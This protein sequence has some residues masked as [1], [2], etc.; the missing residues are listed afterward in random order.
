MILRVICAVALVICGPLRAD[1]VTVFAAASLRNVLTEIVSGYDAGDDVIVSYAGSST[2]ARQIQMGAPADIFISANVDW[3][4][5]LQ[6][7]GLVQKNSTK[8]F[9]SN[10]LVLIQPKG[11]SAPLFTGWD[12]WAKTLGT[13]R[14][15]LAMVDAVPAGIYAKSALQHLDVW[16]FVSPNIVQSDNVRAALALVALGAVDYGVTYETDAL[17]EPKV[18][19][20]ANIPDAS[21]Q[22]IA[23]PAVLLGDSGAAQAFF[24]HLFSQTAQKILRDHGFVPLNHTQ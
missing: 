19:I 14:V 13:S 21:H 3:V 23:Y 4:T 20:V 1:P 12:A 5:V 18:T 16:E 24:D 6:Q 8:V 7:N 22:A 10:R 17:S 11:Q 15:A 2:L 9:A